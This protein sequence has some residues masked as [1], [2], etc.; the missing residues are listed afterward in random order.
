MLDW[1]YLAIGRWSRKHPSRTVKVADR[2]P[3]WLVRRVSEA[4][5][6]HTLRTVYG[7][8][9]AQRE[10]W[11]GAGV[12]LSDIRSADVLQRIPFM[13][14]ADLGEHPEEYVCVPRE[15]LL[16]VM[17]TTGTKG[18]PKKIYFTADDFEAQTRMM[19]TFLRRF[20]GATRVLAIFNT[21]LPTWAAGT[22][23]RRGVEAA[24]MF[25]ILSNTGRTVAEQ[26]QLIK[27]YEIDFIL[28][29]PAYLHRMTVEAKEDLRGLGV[30]YIQ[31]AGQAWPETFRGEIE[32]AWG[33]KLID[34]YGSTEFGCAIAS[35]CAWQ[36]GLHVTEADFWVEIVDP[37][38]G[39]VLPDGEEG[40]IV[41]TTLSRRGMPLVR[42]RTHDLAH[43]IPYEGRCACGLPIRKMSRIRGRLD[44]T[45]IIGGD[46]NVYSDDFDE[47]FLSLRGITDYQIVIEKDSYKDVMHVKVE[48]D[49]TR[50]GLRDDLLK[51]LL[52]IP[53]VKIACETT[54][55]LV[56]GKIEVVP[57][58]TLSRGRA[59]SVRIVDMRPTPT[60]IRPAETL[61]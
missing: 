9:P 28:T 12:E 34:C 59:K 18:T 23:A 25:G 40:E 33:A 7:R 51:A 22:V 48:G 2:V 6:V 11:K 4:K 56:V 44:D 39:E 17:T 55:T 16:H 24:G 27:E 42:Y 30:R 47:A 14:G 43:L 52:G 57:R 21:D 26:I 19:G 54:K 5:L 3:H 53:H 50:S 61:Q 49:G 45:I 58:G 38:T 31:I 10:R 37:E 36:D 35:E 15:E 1:M 20:P 29:M 60:A 41:L 32:E 8:C 13:L 46:A